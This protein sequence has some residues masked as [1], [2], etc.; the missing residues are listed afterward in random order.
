MIYKYINERL[1]EP[2]IPKWNEDKTKYGLSDEELKELGYKSL[3]Q[4][5]PINDLYTINKYKDTTD[6][7]IQ[8][9]ELSSDI[10]T[11]K[12]KKIELLKEYDSSDKINVFY[13][14]N[15]PLWL[16]KSDRVS[17]SYMISIEL[18]SGKDTVD[19]WLNAVKYTLPTTSAQQM[20][21]LLEQYAKECYDVTQNH[22]ATILSLTSRLDVVNYDFTKNYPEKL[23]FNN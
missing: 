17:L 2:Y 9:W 23:S 12:D 1:I 11:V 21:F 7:I 18:Q 22:A 14:N 16:S 3:K 13:L 15:I 4:E 20:L 5:L 19:L 10:N 8:Y 6:N